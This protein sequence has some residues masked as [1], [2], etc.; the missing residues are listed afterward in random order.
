MSDLAL[1]GVRKPGGCAQANCHARDRVK[2]KD[3]SKRFNA[4]DLGLFVKALE[5]ERRSPQG[6][7]RFL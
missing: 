2:R 7:R 4:D 6:L 5:Q 1:V 3:A